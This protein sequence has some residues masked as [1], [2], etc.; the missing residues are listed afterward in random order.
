MIGGAE[1]SQHM[2]LNGA[3]MDLDG[4][5]FKD[6]NNYEMFCFI[7]DYLDFDQLIWEFGSDEN[8]EWVHVSYNHGQNRRQVLK[9]IKKG[10]LTKYVEI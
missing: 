7:R 2:A 10:S 4:D 3:A 9:A 6:P 8:P 5:V 1:N